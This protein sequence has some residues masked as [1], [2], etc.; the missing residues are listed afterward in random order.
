MPDGGDERGVMDKPEKWYVV[1]TAGAGV[2]IEGTQEQARETLN[3]LTATIQELFESHG[4]RYLR[5]EQAIIPVR[6]EAEDEP[7]PV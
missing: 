1:T 3:Q 2:Q 7:L 4:I 6:E 5:K